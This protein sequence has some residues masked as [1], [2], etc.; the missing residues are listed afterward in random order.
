MRPTHRL[1]LASLLFNLPFALL[2]VHRSA[3]DTYTHIFLADHYRWRWWDLW[4]PR[5]YMGFSMASYPPLVHQV[6]ALLAEPLTGLIQRFAPG[7]ESYPNA[8][9]WLGAELASVILLVGVLSLL[10]L[11][12]R[13][14]ARVFVGPRVAGLAAV[15]AIF[16]PSLSLTAWAFGQLPTL[17]ATTLMLGALARGAAF[18]LRGRVIDLAVAV[19]LAGTAAA[20]HHGVFLLVPFAGAAVVWRVGHS[21]ARR[22]NFFL[23]SPL[24]LLRLL[25]WA[26]LSAGLVATVLWP[27]LVWSRG[28][29]LQTS[30]DHASRHNLLTDVGAA[31]FFFWPM[32]GPLLFFLPWAIW[33]GARSGRLFPLLGSSL[34]LFVLGLGGTTPL[35]R[36][37]F[38]AGWEWLTY[39]RFSFWAG[40]MLLPFA[41]LALARTWPRHPTRL[42]LFV[43]VLAGW[44]LVAGGLAV[45]A[46]SQPPAVDLAPI[47]RFLQQ[48][49]QQRYRYL[50]LGFGDQ[51]AKLSTLTY[52]GSPDGSYH[53]AR[54]LPELQT[55]GLGS[56][57]GAVWN[58]NGVKAL[59]PILA[60]AERYGVRWVFVNHPDYIQVLMATGWRFRWYE[61]EVTV[62]DKPGVLPRPMAGPSALRFSP[63]AYWWGSVPLSVLLLTLL[64]LML[65][66][67]PWQITR[68]RLIQI[69]ATLRQVGWATSL[70][71][72]SL[73]WVW[74]IQPGTTPGIYFTYQSVLLYA[75]DALAGLT[76]LAWGVERWLR[77]EPLGFGPRPILYVG[78]TLFAACVVSSVLAYDRALAF[79]FV[80]H[81]I[82]LAGWYVLCINDPPSASTLGWTVAG[83]VLFQSGIGLLQVAAQQT[84]S[85]SLP[86][87]G[88]L[89]A[90]TPGASVVVNAA[91][92]RWLRAYGTMPHPNILGGTLIVYLA[93]VLERFLHTGRRWWL[94]VLAL[95]LLTLWLTFSRA[96]WLGAGVLL[97]G[98][99][100]FLPRMYRSRLRAVVFASLA[101]GAI[102]MLPLLSFL[103]ERTLLSGQAVYVEQRS[104]DIRAG[105]ARASTDM[106][107]THPWAGVGAGNFVKYANRE[108]SPDLPAE[109]V[110]N[111][112]LLI[113]S[114]T[115]LLGGLAYLAGLALVAAYLWQHRRTANMSKYLW[116][117]AVGGVIVSGLFDHFWW[118]L[119]P[120]RMLWVTAIGLWA[121][122][123]PENSAASSFDYGAKARL[124]SG[125]DPSRVS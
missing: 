75:S 14:W 82:L 36:L 16:L 104:L 119:P 43:V 88:A 42:A 6:L 90:Q 21:L 39:D 99:L 33:R 110:H 79:A 55:S 123:I 48:P 116:A 11:A 51:L 64:T 60:H 113:T 78:L 83:A 118:S 46:R 53:T 124:R 58:P 63:E 74:V 27:F 101:V 23:R 122:C 98:G 105:L 12:V 85:T 94:G 7:P 62:W 49:A 19:L 89:T 80:A 20:T 35:P 32:Y 34:I 13:A 91:G 97:L 15:F 100:F 67:R 117:L 72:I 18:M 8:F 95:G 10:P 109:S 93:G 2:G 31:L 30:I 24:Y 112:F 57:D 77:R 59:I 114:E 40:L 102:V 50:T 56:M 92:T 3:F 54:Q 115:G 5:W 106:I 87:P 84:W 65:E 28:Q 81:L 66:A 121:K 73:S 103:W 25:L 71:F 107:L 44:A 29:T 96:A 47:V 45:I 9:R 22:P 52:N 76:L 61:G 86:W 120:L 17:L 125:C 41:A 38:G 111:V 70:I 1:L 37:L 108:A 26:T 4:E 69:F 68:L